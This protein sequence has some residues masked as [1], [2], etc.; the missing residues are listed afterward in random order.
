GTGPTDDRSTRQDWPYH[1]RLEQVLCQPGPPG[2]VPRIVDANHVAALDESVFAL[3]S[4][5]QQ[6]PYFAAIGLPLGRK[7]AGWG[8]GRQLGRRYSLIGLWKHDSPPVRHHNE[9]L[10]NVQR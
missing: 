6:S 1:V 9:S 10:E 7:A 4:L 5:I 3:T 2:L 8:R